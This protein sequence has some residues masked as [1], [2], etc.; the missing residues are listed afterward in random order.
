MQRFTELLHDHQVP[1]DERR[2]LWA[3]RRI[4]ELK[5]RR[6]RVHAFYDPRKAQMKQRSVARKGT[7]SLEHCDVGSDS[8][9][10]STS[11]LPGGFWVFLFRVIPSV[12]SGVSE[13]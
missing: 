11:R 10:P 12:Q 7:L 8:S 2:M 3:E 6:A 5:R 13:N 1:V 9:G 4:G